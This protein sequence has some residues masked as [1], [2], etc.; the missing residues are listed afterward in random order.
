MSRILMLAGLLALLMLS[1]T[2]AQDDRPRPGPTRKALEGELNALLKDHGPT[3]PD[4]LALKARIAALNAEAADG[5]PIN[6]KG[7]LVVLAKD[8]LSATL[9]DAKIRSIAGRSFVVGVEVEGP[10]KITKPMLEGS[11]A[12]IPLDDVVEMVE[13]RE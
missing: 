11:V 7:Y 6:P 9:K 13:V 8:K 10:K 5:T 4:V 12:W 1:A 2:W 3:H